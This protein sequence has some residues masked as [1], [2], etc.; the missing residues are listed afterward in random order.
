MVLQP[1]FPSWHWKR[2]GCRIEGNCLFQVQRSS[3]HCLSNFKS[4]FSQLHGP[5][6]VTSGNVKH[7]RQLC[8]SKQWRQCHT[9]HLLMT[10]SIPLAK[11]LLQQ[12]PLAMCKM[13]LPFVVTMSSRILLVCSKS[14]TAAPKM[15][16]LVKSC[17]SWCPVES[18]S[19]DTFVGCLF[20]FL[21][22]RSPYFRS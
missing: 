13:P 4:L 12:L 20:Y 8:N 14:L 16:N 5:K 15:N 2:N 6:C 18:L 9:L 21:S 3:L 7:S 22:M 1:C 19:T 10:A 17:A 11:I